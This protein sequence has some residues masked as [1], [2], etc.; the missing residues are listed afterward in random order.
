MAN[1]D[2]MVASLVWIKDA[3]KTLQNDIAH[4]KFDSLYDLGRLQGRVT[5]LE[6]AIL[7]IEGKLEEL[8]N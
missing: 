3:I 1:D 6:Q 2:V 5:G 7:I 4:S 8:D